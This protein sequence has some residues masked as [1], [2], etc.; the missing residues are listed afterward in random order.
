MRDEVF[1]SEAM[2][3]YQ[4]GCEHCKAVM[5]G[6]VID[7]VTSSDINVATVMVG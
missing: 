4:D 7:V 6:K 1:Q 5:Q 2:V 3:G